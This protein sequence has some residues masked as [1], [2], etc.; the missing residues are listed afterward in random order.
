MKLG[1]SE[2]FSSPKISVHR[3]WRKPGRQI[4]LVDNETSLNRKAIE[5]NALQCFREISSVSKCSRKRQEECKADLTKSE[6][7]EN[8]LVEK[9]PPV[10]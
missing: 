9:L 4:F 8:S 7:K 5:S 1:K 6:K 2:P 3:V 10:Y